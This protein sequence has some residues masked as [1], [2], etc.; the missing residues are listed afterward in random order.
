VKRIIVT[1]SRIWPFAQVVRDTLDYVKLWQGDF[2]LIHG[3]CPTGADKIAD[4]WAREQDWEPSV[5]EADWNRL[6]KA[7]GPLRNSA[8]VRMGA[9]YCIGFP[10]VGAKSTGSWD[11]LRKAKKAKIQ[12]WTIDYQGK[13]KLL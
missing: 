6:G 4:D 10:L 12:T 8:M 5:F 9:E 11:C 7:A 2:Q 1:G 3:G 13:A